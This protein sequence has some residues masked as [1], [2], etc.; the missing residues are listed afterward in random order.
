MHP[1]I[2]HISFSGG[3]FSGLSYIGVLHFLA[4]EKIH[5][6]IRHISGTSIGALMASVLCMELWDIDRFIKEF[7]PTIFIPRTQIMQLLSSYG[8][9]SSD[10]IVEPLRMAMKKHN[11]DPK[12]TFLELAKRSG[13]R[14]VITASCVETQRPMYFSLETTPNVQVLDAIRASCAI[15]LL[16]QPVLIDNQYYLDGCLTDNH[17]VK[18]CLKE[19]TIHDI[20]LVSINTD[21]TQGAASQSSTFMDSFLGYLSK[22][23]GF[24]IR[25]DINVTKNKTN[26]IQF[27]EPVLSLLPFQFDATGIRLAVTPE[28][29]DRCIVQG[30]EEAHLWYTSILK[31]VSEPVQE[32]PSPCDLPDTQH[33]SHPLKESK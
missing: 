12:I 4:M 18:S 11:Y 20:L 17:P 32:D 24:M 15:P 7:M 29:V 9:V 13:K 19:E 8:V 5:K 16:C 25:T 31:P 1:P 14:L 28:D 6:T 26:V 3:G 33:P 10:L 23:A 21:G 27:R 22:V 30:I 2:T